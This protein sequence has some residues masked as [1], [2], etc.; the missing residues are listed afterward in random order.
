MKSLQGARLAK[1]LANIS[2]LRTVDH[3]IL[4]WVYLY[5]VIKYLFLLAR[6]VL[7]A[8]AVGLSVDWQ[9]LILL[10]P[11]SQL[12]YGFAV[13]PGSIGVYEL[14]WFA[15][16]RSVSEP[17]ALAAFVVLLRFNMIASVVHPRAEIGSPSECTQTFPR[18]Q[19]PCF[20]CR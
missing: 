14:G 15:L 20:C 2:N 13:T 16:L 10:F 7:I 9:R 4:R 12:A 18:N 6:L 8:Y 17:G 19:P 1:F 11:L 5:S 3:R